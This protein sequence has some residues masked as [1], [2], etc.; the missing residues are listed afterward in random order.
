M[1]WL[2]SSLT[3]RQ[4]AQMASSSR[5]AVVAYTAE[6]SGGI[7]FDGLKVATKHGLAALLPQQSFAAYGRAVRSFVTLEGPNSAID[8]IAGNPKPTRRPAD[9]ALLLAIG[10][11]NLRA[12]G[13][14]Q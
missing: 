8:R 9:I 11:D 6:P 13:R 3:G 5:P 2:D 4:T 12:H 14:A 7:H 1:A 10:C